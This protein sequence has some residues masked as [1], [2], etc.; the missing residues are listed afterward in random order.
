LIEDIE[1]DR[2][3][4]A[5]ISSLWAGESI[6]FLYTGC[7]YA[8]CNLDSATVAGAVHASA[9]AYLFATTTIT[10]SG[11]RNAPLTAATLNR[12]PLPK[13]SSAS[14]PAET[15]V[16]AA[17][18]EH[19][20]V[21][22]DP[23]TA[24]TKPLTVKST[25]ISSELV[26]S[27]NSPLATG[28]TVVQPL[29]STPSSVQQDTT[30]PLT[31]AE[32]VPS[33]RTQA[34]LPF[35]S[36]GSLVEQTVGGKA[37]DSVSSAGSSTHASSDSQAQASAPE[38]LNTFQSTPPAAQSVTTKFALVLVSSL[39]S[40][41]VSS[42]TTLVLATRPPE[43]TSQGS[44][45][46]MDIRPSSTVA[47]T[48]LPTNSRVVTISSA[49]ALPQ[50]TASSQQRVSRSSV[51]VNDGD[52]H[53]S[54]VPSTENVAAIVIGGKT[55]ALDASSQYIVSGQ[56]LPFG[57]SVTVVQGLS[58]AVIA[59][60]T[61]S[62]EIATSALPIV[63]G[64]NTIT[65]DASSNYI[66]SGQALAAGSEITIVSGSSS[67]V[68]AL[69]ISNS[70]T[71]VVVGTSTS[72][73]PEQAVVEE[74]MRPPVFTIGSSTITPNSASEYVVASQTLSPGAAVTVS[75]SVISLASH[76]TEIVIGT[77]TETAAYRPGFGEY[78]WSALGGS[79]MSTE[80]E[81]TPGSQTNAIISLGSDSS[82]S[83][84]DSVLSSATGTLAASS[85]DVDSSSSS[86]T[87][88]QGITS[89]GGR[90]SSAASTPANSE[91]QTTSTS[92]AAH[93]RDVGTGLLVLLQ[94]VALVSGQMQ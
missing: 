91:T 32:N 71:Y 11:L 50:D 48:D 60:P 57:A 37:S 21:V 89:T 22:V 72:M 84:T 73:L 61:G 78:V 34:T 25:Q 44:V 85:T 62:P 92:G 42:T 16:G 94:L 12:V 30:Q 69:Q 29:I 53:T 63:V 31:S 75:G 52:S 55:I 20:T 67:A 46:G 38:S 40:G 8:S 7:S 41:E 3:G 58:T 59:L 23:V 82:A 27:E 74:S 18:S 24:E 33:Q 6:G 35:T 86:G 43:N 79:A 15:L 45:S 14:L 68:I 81:T 47:A 28:S 49:A 51:K 26:G 77:S 13:S 93:L 4:T 70:Q 54:S 88:Q 2:I 83:T 64:S 17:S 80:S 87:S 56:S 66:I 36:S 9:V 90:G 19:V 39:A 65:P 76:A 5:E 10:T 1:L